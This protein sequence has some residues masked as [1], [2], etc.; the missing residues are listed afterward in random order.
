M[1]KDN[2]FESR[3]FQDVQS[4]CKPFDVD[5]FGNSCS[6]FN[7]SENAYKWLLSTQNEYIE[8]RYGGI[9]LNSS[10]YAVWYN[11]KGYHSMPVYLNELNSAILKNAV[12]NSKYSITTNNHP[13]KMGEKELTTSSM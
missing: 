10:K 12:N 7:S 8:K 3:V 6:K 2:G 13:L 11:N 5:R 9:S 4:H 1:E